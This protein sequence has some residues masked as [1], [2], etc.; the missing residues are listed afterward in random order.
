MG[1]EGGG[2]GDAAP[3]RG[4]HFLNGVRFKGTYKGSIGDLL[5]GFHILLQTPHSLNPKR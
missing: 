1:G 2:S 4:L 3:Y 5:R